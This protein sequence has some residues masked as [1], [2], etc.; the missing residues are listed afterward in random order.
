MVPGGMVPGK[1]LCTTL[2]VIRIS[3]LD[4]FEYMRIPPTYKERF[5]TGEAIGGLPA[6]DLTGGAL[7]T[8]M[9]MRG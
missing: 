5:K 4:I 7:S 2:N 3:L 9:S 6:N 1:F 8:I